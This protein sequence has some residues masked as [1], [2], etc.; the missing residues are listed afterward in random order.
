MPVAIRSCEELAI[1]GA[2][3]TT[4]PVSHEKNHFSYGGFLQSGSPLD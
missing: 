2:I 4:S 1:T 3:G